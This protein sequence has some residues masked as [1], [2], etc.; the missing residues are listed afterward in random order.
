M[1]V[2]CMIE[3][4]RGD[5][6]IYCGIGSKRDFLSLLT[7]G[8]PYRT[9]AFLFGFSQERFEYQTTRLSRYKSKGIGRSCQ[10]PGYLL[11][12]SQV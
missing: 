6:S 8:R 9:D 12:K 10:A 5:K 1:G 7:G 4:V 11:E 3:S 2:D